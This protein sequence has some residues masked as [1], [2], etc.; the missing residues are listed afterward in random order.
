MSFFY[1]LKMDDRI[2][3]L[4]DGAVLS[5]NRVL[6]GVQSKVVIS[7]FPPY[8]LT[9]RGNHRIIDTLCK[10]IRVGVEAAPVQNFEDVI[11]IIDAALKSIAENI[12]PWP[13]EAHFEMVIAGWGPQGPMLLYASSFIPRLPHA[14][15]LHPFTLYHA[16]DEIGGGP[17]VTADELAGLGITPEKVAASG[18]DVMETYG[19]DLLE[20][21]RR[22]Q[23]DDPLHPEESQ[24]YGIGGFAEVTTVRSTGV[25]KKTVR[26]WDDEIGDLIDPFRG[27][28]E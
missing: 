19:A 3:I 8:A 15:E 4:T 11:V 27:D 14:G 6:I 24:F 17:E 25:E 5:R 9:G 12:Q 22:K 16:G 18:R 28:M 13:N 7:Q 1:C 2:A 20:L 23:G 21:A 26:R 10:S